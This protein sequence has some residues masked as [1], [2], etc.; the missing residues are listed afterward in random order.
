MAT[1]REMPIDFRNFR[2]EFVRE[3]IDL[4]KQYQ[5]EFVK[6]A[7]EKLAAARKEFGRFEEMHTQCTM[8]HARTPTQGS[9]HQPACVVF[10]FGSA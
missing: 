10:L 4:Q 1:A 9:R 6:W 7:A 2:K 5:D 3:L 8:T